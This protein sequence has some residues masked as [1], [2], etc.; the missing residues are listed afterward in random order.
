[1]LRLAH[2]FVE[3]KPKVVEPRGEARSEWEIFKDLS[4]HAGV[5]FLN[6]PLLDG[7][8]RLLEKFGFGF[9]EDLLYR[10]LLF[11]KLGL[12]R[13]K[14]T[15]GGISTDGMHWGEFFARHVRTSDRKLHL[16]PADLADA[17]PEA[18]ATPPSTSEEFPYLLISGARRL[19]SYNSWTHNIGPLMEMMKG[20]CDAAPV[21][22]GTNRSRRRRPRP[23]DVD[24]GLDRDRCPPFL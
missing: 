16:A 23:S 13:L 9:G 20:N 12:G 19:A 21:G 6:D 24:R 17:L 8:A 14:A 5:P 22:C 7:A 4:R 18:L 3:W 15:R 1:M 11:P 10:Y 2:P